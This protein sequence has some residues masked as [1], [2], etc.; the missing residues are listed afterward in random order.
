LTLV[1]RPWEVPLAVALSLT[2]GILLR[3]SFPGYNLH[4]LSA[5]ALAPLLVAIAR[6]E[7]SGLRFLYGWAGGVVYWFTLCTWIQFVLEVHGGMGRWG[8]W[9]C[10]L[11]F[12]VLKA[13]HLGVFAWLACPLM[14]RAYAI[15]AIAALWVGIE[16]THGTFGFAWLAL[17]NAGITMS[18][19][20]RLAPLTGVYG[21]SFV[22]AM[23]AVASA[24][25]I[26]RYPRRFLWPL[27]A[28]LLLYLLPPV[29][30]GVKPNESALIVQ[31]NVNTEEV[32]TEGKERT[33]EDHLKVVSGAFPASLV[34]WPEL[35]APLYYYD[36]PVFHALAESIAKQHGYFLF[37]TVAYTDR[38]QPMNSA[39]LLGPTGGEIA[40]YDKVNLVPFGEFI[41]P[42]F[43][44]VN[45]IT[46][47][48]GDFVPGH[49]TKVMDA[50]PNRLGVFICYES[51][52][53]DFVRQFARGGATVFFNLSN[54]G[55]F[56]RSAAL[57]QHLLL[58]RMR[59][60]ENRRFIVRSTNDGISAAIDPAG[61]ILRQLPPYRE[62][63]ALLP[64][65]GVNEITFY[66][67]HGDWFAWACLIIG[68]ALSLQ[69]QL[70][71]RV[72]RRGTSITQVEERPASG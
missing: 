33:T 58:V 55:Y 3:L 30:Q 5:V 4:W 34:V 6:E 24:L 68:V 44:F 72:R 17:G 35:P 32:W 18:L 36:D 56:G 1:R 59:A 27:A 39:V 54:D 26:L 42:F 13:I 14:W 11:L 7:R 22:L 69:T 50:P 60:V 53:P 62:V 57:E 21:V 38:R 23:L 25:V 37:G 16:R 9:A 63:A 20:L 45:R 52:F 2:T 46:Q 43:G 49:L 10:F 41:P 15:P 51:A 40:R 31:P 66:S 70:A 28:L 19:P 67:R 71:S 12:C 65:S 8:G 48:A 61:R 29:R 64:F 47:E